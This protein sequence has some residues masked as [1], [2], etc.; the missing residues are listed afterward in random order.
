MWISYVDQSESRKRTVFEDCIHTGMDVTRENECP[1]H[2]RHERRLARSLGGRGI[3]ARLARLAETIGGDEGSGARDGRDVGVG[4]GTRG[5]DAFGD[6]PR[7]A[8]LGAR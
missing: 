3:T 6:D 7:V 1:A 5:D 2:R 4:E 8:P